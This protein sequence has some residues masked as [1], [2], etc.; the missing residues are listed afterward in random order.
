MPSKRRKNKD[1]KIMKER[2]HRHRQKSRNL[3]QDNIRKKRKQ[4]YLT[5]TDR[6]YKN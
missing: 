5:E 4:K 6:K 2:L 1:E 3:K